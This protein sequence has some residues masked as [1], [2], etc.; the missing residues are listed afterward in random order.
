[1]CA[2]GWLRGRTGDTKY[3]DRIVTG[4]KC[5]AA[6]PH[7]LFS[8]LS[9]GYDPKTKMLYKIHDDIDVP[10]LAALMGGPE[11]MMEITPLIDLP[12]WNDAWLNYCQ[13]L[14]APRDEQAQA[15]GGAVINAQGVT[16]A[17]MTG[18]AAW[19]LRTIASWQT[20]HG[21]SSWGTR[22]TIRSIQRSSTTQTFRRR[23][24]KF[25]MSRRTQQLSGA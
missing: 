25:R 19:K 11:A 18:Y 15:I 17:K 1:M 23:S 24:M 3:R 20:A 21:N 5:M 22:A 4:M 12:E 2:T 7:Q 13:Y 10:T 14:Q 9:Y 8:G 16:F 6:M